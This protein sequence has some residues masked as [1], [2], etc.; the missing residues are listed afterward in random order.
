MSGQYLRASE[1][2][3]KVVDI[4]EFSIFNCSVCEHP[5]PI[6]DYEGAPGSWRVP[7]PYSGSKVHSLIIWNSN[8]ISMHMIRKSVDYSKA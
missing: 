6:E 5:L 7:H 3:T 2:G 8:F 1:L 4:K